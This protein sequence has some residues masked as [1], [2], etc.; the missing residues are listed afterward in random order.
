MRAGVGPL[1]LAALDQK[2][3]LTP[4]NFISALDL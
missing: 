4:V 2:A 1:R 3:S